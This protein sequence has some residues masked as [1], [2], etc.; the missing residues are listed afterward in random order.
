MKTLLMVY[1]TFISK[2]LTYKQRNILPTTFHENIKMNFTTC[3]LMP[4][5]PF[6]TITPSN[7]PN[8]DFPQQSKYKIVYNA[9]KK[10]QSE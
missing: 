9:S 2:H 8:K 4:L 5:P 7:S 3:R 10:D 6:K 1:T